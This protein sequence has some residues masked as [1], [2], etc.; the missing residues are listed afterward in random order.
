MG[1]AERRWDRQEIVFYNALWQQATAE[2]ITVVIAAGD[3]GSAGCDP[4]PTIDSNA[5]SRGWR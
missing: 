3:N 1:I 5:A 4:N 2:G